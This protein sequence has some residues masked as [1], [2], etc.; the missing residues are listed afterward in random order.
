M[1]VCVALALDLA[2]TL[3]LT[4][5]ART[6]SNGCV[7]LQNGKTALM[8]GALQGC[9]LIVQALVNAG[10]NA[11]LKNKVL[12]AEPGVWAWECTHTH[13]PTHPPTHTPTHPTHTHTPTHCHT[14]RLSRG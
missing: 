8:R 4:P 11:S 12:G 10:A 13:T 7:A 2:L 6:L 1:C 9:D 5:R 3:T 14:H